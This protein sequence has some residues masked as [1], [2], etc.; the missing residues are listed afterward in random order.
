MAISAK[1]KERIAAGIKKFQPVLA[2]AKAADVNESDTVTIIADMLADVFGY[3]KYAEITSEFAIKKT[4]CDLALKVDER[5]CLLIECKA[6]GMS[7]KDDYV[8]QA[9]D[10]AANSGIDWVVLTNG[11]LWKVFKISFTKPIDKELVYEFDF[12]ELSAKKP[13]DVDMIYY[14]CRES[15]GK[16]SKG[17]EELHLQKQIVNKFVITQLLMTDPVA[18]AVRKQIRKLAPEMKTSNDDIISI[19]SNEILKREVVEGEQSV[20]AKKRVQKMIKAE[21]AAAEAKKQSKSAADAEETKPK[22]E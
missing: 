20:D 3:D 22:E 17:L 18:D 1:L 15:L 5:V 11:V 21:T 4:F 2:R 8:K 16:S 12:L 19:I 9:T 7:L 13:S 10:Y 14:L 6:I